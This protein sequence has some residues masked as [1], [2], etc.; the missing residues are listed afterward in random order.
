MNVDLNIYNS[1]NYMKVL[2]N[3]DK[4]NNIII[5]NSR[6]YMK[7]LNTKWWSSKIYESTIVEII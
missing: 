6:N 2:N 3:I 5:Y 1:R 4:Y 7:V